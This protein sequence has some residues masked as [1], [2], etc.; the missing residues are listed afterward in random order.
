MVIEAK[1]VMTQETFSI[2]VPVAYILPY[3]VPTY[4]LPKLY[5]LKKGRVP[6]STIICDDDGA[7]IIYSSERRHK[8]N[9]VRPGRSIR[10]RIYEDVLTRCTSIGKLV[11]TS[12]RLV[13]YLVSD[14][15]RCNID[16][17]AAFHVNRQS[18]GCSTLPR[19]WPT[20][21]IPLVSIT[22]LNR[23]KPRRCPVRLSRRTQIP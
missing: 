4:E 9:H 12:A 15:R 11:D 14:M 13:T 17:A 21:N 10:P 19:S 16:T 3:L 23:R 20:I 6:S 2:E 7:V 8:N 1:R 18:W 22:T 5:R